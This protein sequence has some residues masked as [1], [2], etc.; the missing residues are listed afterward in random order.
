[1]SFQSYRKCG[2]QLNPAIIANYLFE[3]AKDFNRFYQETP[4]LKEPEVEKQK[5]I[6]K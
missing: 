6:F 3:L 2:E 5:I 1:M 4:I